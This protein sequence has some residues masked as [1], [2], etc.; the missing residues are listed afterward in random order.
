LANV[1]RIKQKELEEWK[2]R[3]LHKLQEKFKKS[4]ENVGDAHRAA[5]ECEK[6]DVWY[7]EKRAME[8]A[9]AQ[10]RGRDA[11][12]KL[13]R[14]KAENEKKKERK[15]AVV[16][17]PGKSIG[18]QVSPPTQDRPG[19]KIMEDIDDSTSMDGFSLPN[20]GEIAITS[21]EELLPTPVVGNYNPNVYSSD[22]P[23]TF[24][25]NPPSDVI[26]KPITQVSDYL[27]RRRQLREQSLMD[28]IEPRTIPYQTETV[29]KQYIQAP[30]TIFIASERAN[31][32][33]TTTDDVFKNH[34]SS[35]KG[36]K[37]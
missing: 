26:R 3:N 9:V 10:Q 32:R 35:N 2:R 15:K 11:G 28:D 29:N 18:I 4:I 34:K 14:E 16:S 23:I 36:K 22:S 1:A 31:S 27:K 20:D 25:T 19:I 21:D 37:L 7:E 5:E 13:A 17:R 33:S 8:Q 12:V 30:Q 6:C 24:D